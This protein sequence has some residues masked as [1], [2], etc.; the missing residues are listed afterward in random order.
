MWITS[1]LIYIYI[2]LNATRDLTWAILEDSLF[3]FKLFN[4]AHSFLSLFEICNF[5]SISD[6][7]C[8][9]PIAAKLSIARSMCNFSHRF[10]NYELPV[11]LHLCITDFATVFDVPS[12]LQFYRKFEICSRVKIKHRKM[13]SNLILYLCVGKCCTHPELTEM[14]GWK[15]VS[16]SWSWRKTRKR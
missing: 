10:Y 8:N 1:D 5:S 16:D 6:I 14:W 4:I 12:I 13:C 7:L 9:L 2:L 11:R 3:A 15:V